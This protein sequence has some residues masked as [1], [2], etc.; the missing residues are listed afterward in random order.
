MKQY[1]LH[2]RDGQPSPEDWGRVLIPFAGNGVRLLE[3]FKR[4]CVILA[5]PIV[6]KQITGYFDSVLECFDYDPSEKER[7]L[8]QSEK[9]EEDEW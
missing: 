4:D 9:D 3:Q 7:L 5:G 8:R 6:I 1:R 2:V